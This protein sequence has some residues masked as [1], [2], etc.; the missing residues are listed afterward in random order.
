[1]EVSPTPRRGPSQQLQIRVGA[2]GGSRSG[3][4]PGPNLE[5]AP[6]LD[7]GAGGP[8]RRRAGRFRSGE[9]PGDA[10]ALRAQVLEP[11]RQAGV[12]LVVGVEVARAALTSSA[13]A[14]TLA[15]F[16]VDTLSRRGPSALAPAAWDPPGSRGVATA[17]RARRGRAH[18]ARWTRPVQTGPGHGTRTVLVPVTAF[19]AR[20]A[21]TMRRCTRPAGGLP[22]P[23][24]A[25][26]G[27]D[28]HHP[29]G[30]RPA[31]PGGRDRRLQAPRRPVS[32]SAT[33]RR[34][35]R[36]R[37]SGPR[38]PRARPQRAGP[39]PSGRSAP[40]ACCPPSPTSRAPRRCPGSPRAR[41]R[42]WKPSASRRV[43]MVIPRG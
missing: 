27:R 13:T 8:R 25:L 19:P 30:V 9:P 5:R 23:P 15:L 10:P 2:C 3:P 7:L 16:A 31:A 22:R 40:A 24:S 29:R 17:A 14:S 21:R 42:A 11:A 41:R 39:S 20:S 4:A 37:R 38:P 33:T 28:A 1:M 34:T 18:S 35:V 36:S 43:S 6:G 12:V 32:A 26:P